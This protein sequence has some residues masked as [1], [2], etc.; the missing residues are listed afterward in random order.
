MI[1]PFIVLASLALATQ[2]GYIHLKGP[3]GEFDIEDIAT[4]S[5]TNPMGVGK[6]AVT[7]HPFH[8]FWRDRGFQA[9]ATSLD[10]ETGVDSK[11]GEYYLQTAKLSGNASV[12][13]DSEAAS[14]YQAKQ[15]G[16]KNPSPGHVRLSLASEIIDYA[17][18]AEVGTATLP[19]SFVATWA[20]TGEE[21]VLLNKVKHARRYDEDLEVHG[22][23][24]NIEFDTLAN[25]ANPLRK[26]TVI[27]PATFKLTKTSTL[28]ANPEPNTTI[29]GVAD[30][31]DLDFVS[32]T[33]TVTLTGNVH[34]E[35]SGF[36]YA[37]TKNGPAPQTYTG[38]M[39]AS[40]AVLTFGAD[41]QLER[42]DMDSV[43]TNIKP[44]GGGR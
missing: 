30:R 4:V 42:I 10:G 8:L 17:G 1:R 24:G 2:A 18:D 15:T 34:F 41:G 33:K 26:G 16:T 23:S 36:T 20:K 12:V 5:A 40:R 7:G 31:I 43:V 29:N 11:S 22:V 19:Q 28:D 3:R 39:Q 21:S 37:E 35:G 14:A 6:I 25:A 13:T 38:S 32:P 27:G 9:N 44:Q